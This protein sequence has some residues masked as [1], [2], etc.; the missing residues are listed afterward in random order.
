MCLPPL[1]RFALVLR[2]RG[3][4][5]RSQIA[6]AVGIEVAA[7]EQLC[8]AEAEN[9]EA[10]QKALGAS[11]ET[12]IAGFDAKLPESTKK[13][14]EAA[15][16]TIAAPLEAAAKAAARKKTKLAII[17]AACVVAILGAIGLGIALAPKRLDKNLT[18]YADIVIADYGTITVKLDQKAA[19]RTAA[20]F[21]MLAESGFYDGLT[22]HRI[23][24]GFMMQGGDP[25]GDGTGSSEKPIW[26]E[27]QENGFNNPLSHTRG[28]ISMARRGDYNSGSCQ[29]FIVHQ[30]SADTLDGKYACFGYV[31]EGMEIVDEIC[32]AARPTNNNGS[33]A[34]DQ[35]PVITTITI[36]TE[37][38]Q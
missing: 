16:D 23:M 21:V 29:F 38:K 33:I 34:K 37:P 35:Q 24:D 18:Y 28:A 8:A 12:L 9:L 10:A 6:K 36:R 26:G 31:T 4:M 17:A 25:N 27:F 1:Q 19:P 15:V 30:D 20:N 5:N 32:I 3:Q 13:Q 14:L 2:I 22:F 7:A 11:L